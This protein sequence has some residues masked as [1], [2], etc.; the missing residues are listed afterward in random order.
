[1]FSK[2]DLEHYLLQNKN[3]G[4]EEESK[5]INKELFEN[6]LPSAKSKFVNA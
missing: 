3:S 5:E 1:V 6:A 2:V 4:E